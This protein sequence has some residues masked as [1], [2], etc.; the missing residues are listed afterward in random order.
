[1]QRA[2]LQKKSSC[3]SISCEQLH[4]GFLETGEATFEQVV[5]D[6]HGDRRG[7]AAELRLSNGWKINDDGL[8]R[9]GSVAMI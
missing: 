6:T 1:M 2:L 9:C 4:T 5:A 8:G 7:F 3:P